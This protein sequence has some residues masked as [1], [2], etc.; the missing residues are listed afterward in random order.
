MKRISKKEINLNTLS[1]GCAPCINEANKIK[2]KINNRNVSKI[3]ID[4]IKKIVN[5]IFK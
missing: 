5:S 1:T 2:K 4:E 3:N